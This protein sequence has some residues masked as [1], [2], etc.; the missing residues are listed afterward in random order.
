[1]PP[2]A[3]SPALLNWFSAYVAKLTAIHQIPFDFG[4]VSSTEKRTH[5]RVW[6]S[7]KPTHGFVIPIVEAKGIGSER[8]MYAS[9]LGVFY[10]LLFS[11]SDQEV[12][13]WLYY[14]PWVEAD[15]EPDP[16]R[17]DVWARLTR[18]DT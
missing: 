18:E 6:P 16:L 14:K 1:M 5:V 3:V 4:I 8:P 10:R 17:P 11:M 12:T 7:V 2:S 9:D 15:E 13:F